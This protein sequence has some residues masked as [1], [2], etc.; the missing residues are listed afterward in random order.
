MY[1]ILFLLFLSG[2]WFFFP[3]PKQS[4][5]EESPPVVP[6]ENRYMLGVPFLEE[7][8]EL[9]ELGVVEEETPEGWV[10]MKWDETRFLYW[11]NRPIQYKYLETVGRKYCIVYNCRDNYINIFR[12][13]L[14]AFEKPVQEQVHPEVFASFKQYNTKRKQIKDK[15]V[16]NERCNQYVWKGKISEYNKPIVEPTVIRE[17]SYSDFKK[18]VE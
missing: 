15:V 9:K 10:R 2:G 16:V 8:E 18:N 7:K 5:P 4:T 13:L 12:E 11:S 3:K 17:V 14:V 6:F 1:W